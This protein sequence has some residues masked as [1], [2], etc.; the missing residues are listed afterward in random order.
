MARGTAINAAF[1]IALN[2][3]GFLKGFIV[4]G[5]MTASEF[6]VWGLL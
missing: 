4:A 6:G 3:L 2:G 1:D 5:L